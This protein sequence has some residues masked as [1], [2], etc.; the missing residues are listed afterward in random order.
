MTNH[1]GPA[2]A[3]VDEIDEIRLTLP[4]LAPY[5]RV[6]RLAITGLASRNGFT[7]DEVEDLRI[8]TGEAFSV[9]VDG[10][11]D[12]DRI[13]FTCRLRPDVLEVDVA[14]QPPRPIAEV[15]ELSRQILEA[16]LDRVTIDERQGTIRTAKRQVEHR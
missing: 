15:A 14:R 16:V 8:A 3:A 5:A 7:Y 10:A 9:L 4:A 11:G 2:R 13:A 6:A 1:P 12:D